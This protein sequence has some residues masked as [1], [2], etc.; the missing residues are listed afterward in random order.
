MSIF[1]EHK[2]I[3]DRSSSDRRRHREKI[4]RA[5]REGIHHI[6]AEESIIGKDGKKKIKI[7]VR[8]IKEYKFVYG[9]NS[10]GQVGTAPGKNIKRGDKFSNQQANQPGGGQAGNEEG[11]EYYEVE[12]TLDELSDYLFHDLE[13]P[14]LIKKS[15]KKLESKKIKRKGYR[16]A[17]IRPRLDKKETVKRMLRRKNIAKRDSSEEELEEFPFNDRDLRYRHFKNSVSYSSNAVIFFIMDISGSMSTNK[18][19]LARSFFFLLYHFI[20]SRYEN[21][22]LVFIA[23]D[24]KAHE[25]SEEQF[26]QRGSAGGTIVSSSLEMMESIMMKRYH[27]ENWN[28]YAFQCSDGDNWPSDN[29]EVSKLL[30]ILKPQCQMFGYC[31][32][33]PSSEQLKWV[34][35]TTLWGCMKV[36]ADSNLKLAKVSAKSDVWEAFN[37][38]F[39]GKLANV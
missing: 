12:I 13:L 14:D 9:D 2:T 25:C 10:G 21:T 26:F 3:A 33:E 18:K 11:E 16:D 24:I 39:G 4:E 5:I 22:E 27:P 23:H 30:S 32:I 19:Y 35:E 29:E 38:F 15:I 17:G 37:H 36:F 1:K 20:R 8:G 6:V 28:V 31:E 34:E 7:P